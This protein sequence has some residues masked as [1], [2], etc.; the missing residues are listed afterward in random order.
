[1]YWCRVKCPVQRN[2]YIATV[3]LGDLFVT[4]MSK[5]SDTSDERKISVVALAVGANPDITS[6]PLLLRV[7]LLTSNLIHWL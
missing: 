6:L 1:M 2:C 7:R 5:I 4:E 3:T